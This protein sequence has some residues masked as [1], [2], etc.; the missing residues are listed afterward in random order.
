MIELYIEFEQHT[1]LDVVGEEVNVDEFGDINWEED[2]NDNEEEFEANYEVDDKN[3]AGDLAG[4]STVQN[5]ADAIVSQHPFGVLSFMRTLDLKV[6]HALKFSEYTNIYGPHVVV[7]GNVAVEDGEFS[8]GIEFGSRES[9]ISAIKSYTIS[10]GVD[11]TVCVEQLP[12]LHVLACCANQ[13]L[14]WQVYVHDVYKM[15]EICKVYKGEF[16]P[17]GDPSMWDIY[18]GTKVTANWTLKRVT[19]ERPKS[20]RYL[21]EMDSRDMRGPCRCTICRREGHSRSRCP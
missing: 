7:E 19:K 12:C 8:V 15:F 9:V 14:D 10:R 3:D 11:Y 17:M 4:N 16:V 5:E 21:N 18:E 13:R 1:G 2:N 6:M 20:T